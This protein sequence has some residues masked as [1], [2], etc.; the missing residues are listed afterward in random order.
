MMYRVSDAMT[1]EPLTVAPDDRISKAM[2][3]MKNARIRHLP[4]V[5]DGRLIGLLTQSDIFAS[6]AA[7]GWRVEDVM[8]GDP[9]TTA[10]G[11]PLRKAARVLWQKKFGCLPVV[12]ANHAVIGILTGH[13]L[14]DPSSTVDYHTGVWPRAQFANPPVEVAPTIT[15]VKQELEKRM[16]E[17][18]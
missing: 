10:E 14:K 7:A 11:S 16:Q 2:A 5:H 17:L 13:L 4:V 6:K 1:R 8:V 3:L 15:A 12:D 9:V 18:G